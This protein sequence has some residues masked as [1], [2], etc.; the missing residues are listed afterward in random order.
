MDR[1]PVGEVVYEK[2]GQG[3][4]TWVRIVNTV[5][6]MARGSTW[7]FKLEGSIAVADA[8]AWTF[9]APEPGRSAGGDHGVGLKVTRGT[10]VEIL[11]GPA[12]ALP[13]PL[14]RWQSGRARLLKSPFVWTKSDRF[15]TPGGSIRPGVRYA[16]STKTPRLYSVAYAS[17][18][19]EIPWTIDVK[20]LKV[21]APDAKR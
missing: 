7:N 13:A 16:L 3:G 1:S 20:S 8:V 11:P 5:N 15:H 6:S 2:A 14:A 18:L 12:L 10:T 9:V 4:R 19:R 21:P 17:S